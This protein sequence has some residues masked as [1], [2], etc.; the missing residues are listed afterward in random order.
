MHNR[1]RRRAIEGMGKTF[2]TEG[3]EVTERGPF[4]LCDLCALRGEI[5][6]MD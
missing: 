5:F 1:E 4:L 3:T 2:T 6:F